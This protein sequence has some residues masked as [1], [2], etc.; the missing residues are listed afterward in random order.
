MKRYVAYSP[1][2]IS[3]GGGGTDI[4]PFCDT[5]GGAVINTTIDRGVTVKYT[6]DPYDIEISS[7]DFLKRFLIGKGNGENEVLN[8]M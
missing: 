8:K 2:R 6:P 4:S 1:F 3:F 7:R 5:H